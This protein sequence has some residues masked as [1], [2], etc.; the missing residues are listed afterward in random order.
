M[1]AIEERKEG[2]NNCSFTK[3]V[4][5]KMKVFHV[6]ELGSQLAPL[7]SFISLCPKRIRDHSR[8]ATCLERFCAFY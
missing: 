7:K 6:C 8:V 3:D 1:A 5:Q 2:E 4:E